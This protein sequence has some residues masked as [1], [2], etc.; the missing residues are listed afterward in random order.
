MK[1]PLTGIAA[2]SPRSYTSIE[3]EAAAFRE[4]LNLTPDKRFDAQSF[5]EIQIGDLEVICDGKTVKLIEGIEDC[6]QEGLTRWDKSAGRME[7]ILS[8]ETHKML[9]D[10]HV[11]ARSTVAHEAG[12]AAMHTAQIIRLAGMSLNSQVAFHRN[13]VE[14]KAYYDTEWQANAFGS[15]L[16]M[17]AA[18]LAIL[19]R[20]GLLN[21]GSVASTYTVST[22]SAGYRIE[23]YQK[24]LVK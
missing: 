15:A 8:L 11:R 4:C 6:T 22:E 5:F 21:E 23:T 9:L 12:H 1:K 13:R 19:D 17:P 14:H 24:Y 3:Q 18:G 16:L 7:L 10:D 20:K 2:D